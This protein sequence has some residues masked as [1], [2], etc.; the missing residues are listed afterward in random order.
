M[1]TFPPL[2]AYGVREVLSEDTTVRLVA[3]D[4]EPQAIAI[5]APDGVD[6]AIL[7]EIT[8]LDRDTYGEL[9]RVWPAIGVLVLAHNPSRAQCLRVLALGARACVSESTPIAQLLMAVHLA[10]DGNCLHACAPALVG[11]REQRAGLLSLTSRERSVL[12]HLSAARS[13]AEIALALQITV[14]TA[15]SHAASIYRKLGVSTR[16]ELIGVD[17]RG[18][19]DSEALSSDLHGR[20]TSSIAVER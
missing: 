19:L 20:H 16:R 8:A 15:R 2:L 10:S 3:T 17:V 7:D 18:F 5:G 1:G 9:E 4:L 14:E 6:V 11:P 12:H 13:N